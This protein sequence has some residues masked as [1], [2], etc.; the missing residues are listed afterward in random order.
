MIPTYMFLFPAVC[1]IAW[2]LYA[3]YRQN[4]TTDLIILS[5]SA[6]V[7]LLNAVLVYVLIIDGLSVMQHLLQMAAASLIVPLAYTY[8]A[9]Q[10]GH[11]TSNSTAVILLWLLA[12][13]T[14]IPEIIIYN[15]FEPFVMPRGGVEPFKLY[16]ISHGETV[17]STNT[18]DFVAVLQCLITIFRIVPLIRMLKEYNLRLSQKVYALLACWALIIVFIV[19]VSGMSTEELRSPVGTYFY[20]GFYSLVLIFAG[21]LIAKGYDLNPVE[22]KDNEAVEDLGVYVQQQYSAL[23]VKMRE[24]MEEQRLYTN[25]QLTAE[26]V[27]ERLGTNHTYFSHMMSSV[28]GMS[29]SEYLNKLRLAHVEKLLK[30]DNLTISSIASQSG[31]ADAGYMSRKFK[32]KYGKTPSEWR[33]TQ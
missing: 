10:V 9:R 12:T 14:Y 1:A 26:S 15:P 4:K 23:S 13:M 3:K 6:I 31:F 24:L 29:F 33:K 32:A 8:F 25:P 2:A 19:M 17:Y 18:G 5:L 22:T 7:V 27:I 21:T 16:V 30:D 11:Q 28:W 20:F